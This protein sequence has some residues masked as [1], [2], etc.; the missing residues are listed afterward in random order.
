MV[1]IAMDHRDGSSPVQHLRATNDTKEEVRGPKRYA[2]THTKDV[3]DGRDEQLRIRMWELALMYRAVLDMDAGKQ[4]DNLDLNN[5]ASK[6]ERVD[7]LGIFKG[8][9]DLQTPG[10]VAWAG[11]SFGAATMVQFVK[12]VYYANDAPAKAK[13]LYVPAKE[14]PLSMQITSSSPLALFDLWGLPLASTD[15]AWLEERRLPCY[16]TS[17]LGGAAVLSVLSEA[18]HNWRGNLDQVKTALSPPEAYTGSPPSIFYPTKSQHFS[19]SDFGILFPWLT[20]RFMS[21][22]EPERVLNLNLRAT[23][24]MLR[25]AGVSIAATNLTA[26]DT[27]ALHA[28]HS[29]KSAQNVEDD[30]EI[31]AVPSTIRGWV[32]VDLGKNVD[33]DAAMNGSKADADG[34]V[35]HNPSLAPQENQGGAQVVKDADGNVA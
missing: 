10:K 6:K 9:L 30:L 15:Q 22:S 8:S 34:E 26:T 27:S 14:S 23:L 3:F 4:L 13:P 33:G 35:D 28:A 25:N 1:V 5:S 16:T 29:H 11:H 18:F 12:S 21:A 19:Q 32:P 2:H 20:E 7:V 31:L 17:S 24:Q